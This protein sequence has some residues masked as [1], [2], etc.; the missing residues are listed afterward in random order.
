[1]TFS[2]L[3]QSDPCRS[4]IILDD[5]CGPLPTRDIPWLYDP[6]DVN[7]AKHLLQVI[8]GTQMW[9]LLC[10][11]QRLLQGCG[12]ANAMGG[13]VCCP[14]I[15]PAVVA[16]PWADWATKAWLWPRRRVQHLPGG[17]WPP[18]GSCRHA[19]TEVLF[20]KSNCKAG[21]TFLCRAVG[22]GR[23]NSPKQNRER[24]KTR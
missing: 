14:H 10:W 22:S 8:D 3:S 6:V 15:L 23:R 24:K 21:V 20:W 5:P 16:L 17:L 2:S 13:H 19:V 18:Q 4:F 9:N 11:I 12:A 7:C 1:M